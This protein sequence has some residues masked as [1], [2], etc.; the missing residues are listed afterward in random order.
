MNKNELRSLIKKETTIAK[1]RK[2][3]QQ[4]VKAWGYNN[5]EIYV[6]CFSTCDDEFITDLLVEMT[7]G[8]DWKTIT[9]AS[10]TIDDYMADF[11]KFEELTRDIFKTMKK[12]MIKEL[13]ECNYKITDIQDYHC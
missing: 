8:D 5:T 7:D 10:I 6:R 1:A 11:Y 3:V 12:N 9:L 2:E 4:Q 13:M